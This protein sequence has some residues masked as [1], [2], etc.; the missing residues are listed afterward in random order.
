MTFTTSYFSSSL[1]YSAHDFTSYLY[2]FLTTKR[3]SLQHRLKIFAFIENL[4]G[5]VIGYCF[6]LFPFTNYEL[7]ECVA[8]VSC[9]Y[10]LMNSLL[11]E[12]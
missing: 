7:C 10:F 1:F 3:T 5:P 9:N 4:C 6:D 2:A 8:I 11:F 12:V